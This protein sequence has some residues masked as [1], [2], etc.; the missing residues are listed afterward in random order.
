MK[1]CE[2]Q[3]RILHAHGHLLV[4]GGPGAGKTTISILK[5]AQVVKDELNSGQKVL[6]LSFARATIARVIEA[7][8]EERNIDKV[9]KR[10][11]DVDTYHAFFWRILKTYG[12]LLGLPRKISI[13]TPA[14]EAIALAQIRSEFAVGRKS[15]LSELEKT[16]RRARCKEA[17][18]KEQLRLAHEEGRICFDMFARY[19]GHILHGSE[20]IRKIIATMHPVIILDEFQ[21]TN[22]G[23]W[24]AVDALGKN[25]RLIAL[26]D[27]EQRIYDWIGADP[28]RLNHFRLAF[29]PTE[30]NLQGI[31]HRSPGTD[32]AQFGNHIL[33]GQF[34]SG[35]YTG[36][37][38]ELYDPIENAAMTKLVL[39]IYNARTRLINAGVKNW[40]I[41]ILVP[42]KKMT[43]IV[44]DTLHAPPA[45]LTK[46]S[47]TASVEMEAAILGSELIAYLLQPGIYGEHFK[48]FVS[49]MQDYYRGK[50]GDAPTQTDLRE[51]SKIQEAYEEWHTRGMQ[52]L[53]V[54]K[55][56]ILAAT[57]EVYEQ[58]RAISLTGNPD[59]DWL[60]IRT[61]LLSGR[62]ERLKELAEETRNVRLL[63][64]GTQLR[65]QLSLD[66]REKG[67]YLNALEIT[68]QAFL[69]EHFSTNSK[70]ESGVVVMNMH[71][72][73]GK[74]FDE[75]II[76][77]A[78]PRIVR[79]EIVANP[80]RIVW[81]NDKANICD[82]SCQNLRVSI[83]RAKRL[84]T[85]MTPKINPCVLLL[86]R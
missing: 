85:I 55:N 67:S 50:G 12:Y 34:K 13:L 47:H 15:Q 40:S 19:V 37:E 57:L 21:D 84:V 22:H 70:P 72:A 2:Q 23:Q 14:M 52:G 3:Q 82:Q 33:N 42:T 11:I 41:A 39:L 27:P 6:F 75:V 77:D 17:V 30:F 45:G 78:W 1:L 7:I 69:R 76:F 83:T 25:S 46:I 32:I 18:E 53:K 4:I 31:N 61:V 56:S 58:T 73:K 38:V 9:H 20:Q 68:K 86:P 71:K 16:E 29:R 8:E 24:V 63:Q 36:V 44:S 5:A 80:D 79:R 49:L 65:D 54:R 43:R 59:I 60:A 28:E 64:R 26:A 81:N 66:W 35:S 10:Q 48:Q 62:C 51:A 74:Q